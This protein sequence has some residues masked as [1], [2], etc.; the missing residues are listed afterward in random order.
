MIKEK[1]EIWKTINDFPNYQVSNTGKIKRIEHKIWNGRGYYTVSEQILKP[2]KNR[3]GYLQLSLC[4]ENKKKTMLVHRL[5]CESFLKNPYNLPQV[6]HKNE[7]KTDNR[8]E[9]LEFC[10]ASYNVNFGTRNERISK[11]ILCIDTGK[12]YPSI[13]EIERQ[14]GFD[15]GHICACCQGKRKSCCGFH[16]QYV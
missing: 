2:S 10:D 4:N 6:N 12:I 14:L 3:Y 7:I 1:E 8:L 9:N 11:K 13:I 16:W 15:K 5:V